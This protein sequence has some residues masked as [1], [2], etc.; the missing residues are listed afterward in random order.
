MSPPDPCIPI[1]RKQNPFRSERNLKITFSSSFFCMQ[2][3]HA[4]PIVNLNVYAMSPSILRTNCT[5]YAMSPV[6]LPLTQKR[7]QCRRLPLH[8]YEYM[9]CRRLTRRNALPICNVAAHPF[10]VMHICNVA[11]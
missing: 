11:A 9:Q 6:I 3:R 5:E 7:M 8:N 4:I 2:C 10:T 1:E